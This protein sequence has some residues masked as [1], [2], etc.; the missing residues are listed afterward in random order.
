METLDKLEYL[1]FV[2]NDEWGSN[3]NLDSAR[4]ALINEI[5]TINPKQIISICEKEDEIVAWVLL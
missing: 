4:N 3:Y 5:K 1:S 2:I